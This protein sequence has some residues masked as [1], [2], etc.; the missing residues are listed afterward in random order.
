M[1]TPYS[2]NYNLQPRLPIKVH[3]FRCQLQSAIKVTNQRL[4]HTVSTKVCNQGCWSKFICSSVNQSLQTVLPIKLILSST[5]NSLQS[6]LLIIVYVIWF[7]LKSATRM[8]LGNL[9][10][11]SKQY[12]RVNSNRMLNRIKWQSLIQKREKR[13]WLYIGKCGS[14]TG[15]LARQST[16]SRGVLAEV[17]VSSCSAPGSGA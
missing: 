10:I 12:K 15:V 4:D 8:S 3:T 5:N 1:F 16:V 11:I 17:V 2:V 7:Q 14:W 9:F 13:D 6:R